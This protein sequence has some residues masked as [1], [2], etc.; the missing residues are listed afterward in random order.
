VLQKFEWYVDLL[1]WL[2][3]ELRLISYYF[4]Q[5]IVPVGPVPK[6]VLEDYT[7]KIYKYRHVSLSATGPT[8]S[9]YRQ[10][11]KTPFQFMDWNN[12]YMHFRFVQV[13]VWLHPIGGCQGGVPVHVCM[14]VCLS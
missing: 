14:F 11:D 12:S 9:S 4:V 7:E 6:E 10:S 2:H 8:R 1:A 5:A 13:C 3:R